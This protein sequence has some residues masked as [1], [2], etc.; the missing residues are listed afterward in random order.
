M[1]EHLVE[2]HLG[3]YYISDS[4]PEVIEE[5]CELEQPG[6]IRLRERHFIFAAHHE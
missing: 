3:G 1:L 5:Y 2:G 6:I 4:D